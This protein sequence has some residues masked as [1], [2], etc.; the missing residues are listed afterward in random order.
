VF[1]S[2]RAETDFQVW[3]DHR[4]FTTRKYRMHDTGHQLPTQTADGRSTCFCGDVITVTVLRE[5][6]LAAH[7]EA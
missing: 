6:I 3:R 5:H 7:V 2:N 1:L 4:A